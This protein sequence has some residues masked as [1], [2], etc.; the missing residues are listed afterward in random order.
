MQGGPSI[1][2]LD[3]RWGSKWRAGR[4]SEPQIFFHSLWLEV[5]MEI[6]HIAHSQR[7][8]EDAAIWQTNYQQQNMGH[9]AL[10]R[11]YLQIV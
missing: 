3:H 2:I 9:G 5:I 10:T 7:T 4:P 8:G 11:P 6:K 1:D